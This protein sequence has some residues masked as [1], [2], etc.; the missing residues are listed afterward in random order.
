MP[1]LGESKEPF[2]AARGVVHGL[3][4]AI[5]AELRDVVRAVL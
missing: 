5:I 2:V 1:C 3:H 4:A